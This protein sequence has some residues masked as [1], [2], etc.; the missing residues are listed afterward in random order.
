M[1]FGLIKLRLKWC[2]FITQYAVHS[3]LRFENDEALDFPIHVFF[4]TRDRYTQ[5]WTKYL[6]SALLNLYRCPIV[7]FLHPY[8]Y[9]FLFFAHSSTSFPLN[10]LHS[11][12]VPICL[13][14]NNI[15]RV[16]FTQGWYLRECSSAS[17]PPRHWRGLTSEWN[18]RSRLSFHV[19]AWAKKE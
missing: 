2:S 11:L 7:R 1:V 17:P 18:D 15:R 3:G 4:Y 5:R 14:K 6:G 13:I 9:V 16:V 10:M 12:Q 19:D 8:T